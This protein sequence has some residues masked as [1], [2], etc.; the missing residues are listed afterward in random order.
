MIVQLALVGRDTLVFR[1]EHEHEGRAHAVDMRNWRQSKCL[2]I[3]GGGQN[4]GGREGLAEHGVVPVG[5]V[6]FVR[7]AEMCDGIARESGTEDVGI[8]SDN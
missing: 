2:F 1:T 3:E 8:L 4:R 6:G 7:G 5:N